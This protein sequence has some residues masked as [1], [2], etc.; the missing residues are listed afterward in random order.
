MLIANLTVCA[1]NFFRFCDR[2]RKF[3]NIS[4]IFVGIH[5][6]FIDFVLAAQLRRLCD[7][8]TFVCV[9]LFLAEPMPPA[10][11]T[12]VWFSSAMFDIFHA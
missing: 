7:L 3:F 11:V 5:M 4:P 1:S 2:S 12:V 10:C 8:F 6:Q 9:K